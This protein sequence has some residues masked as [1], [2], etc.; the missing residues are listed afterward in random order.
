VDYR[1][2]RRQLTRGDIERRMAANL[3]EGFSFV[4]ANWKK[5]KAKF[6]SPADKLMFVAL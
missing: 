4:S 5:R 2:V 6:V 3:P 1:T